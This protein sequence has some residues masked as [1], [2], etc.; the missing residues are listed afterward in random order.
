MTQRCRTCGHDYFYGSLEVPNTCEVCE[1]IA[2]RYAKASGEPGA[3]ADYALH[4]LA[5]FLLLFRRLPTKRSDWRS[6]SPTIERF[7]PGR[8]QLHELRTL[9]LEYIGG[10]VMGWR[11]SLA[12]LV[13]VGWWGVQD[14]VAPWSLRPWKSLVRSRTHMLTLTWGFVE[15]VS[16]RNLS[17]YIGTVRAWSQE[18]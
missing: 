8:S 10:K 11:P 9:A 13:E 3:D 18:R 17:M 7:S 1:R 15:K 12:R 5:H 14:V 4:E 2:E 6:I 16:P